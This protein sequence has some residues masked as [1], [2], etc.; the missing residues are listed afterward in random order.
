MSPIEPNA[1]DRE[2]TLMA[3]ETAQAPDAVEA[4]L[5]AHAEIHKSLAER[6]RARPPKLVM[7]C[8]RGS[9]D[10]AATYAKYL[11]EIHTGTPVASAAPAIASVYQVSLELDGALYLAVSQ[12][13]KSPDIVASARRARAAGA[14]V[15]ALVN[16]ASSPLAEAAEICIP[17][18]AG[19]EH[20]VAATKSFI[21]SLSAIAH[22]AAAW[23]E[24]RSLAAGLQRLPDDL[25]AACGMNWNQAVPDLVCADDLLVVGRG[26]GLALAQEAALKLKETASLHAEAFSAAELRH[27]P[28][29]IMRPGLPVLAFAQRDETFDSLRQLTADLTDKGARLMVAGAELDKTACLP[30]VEGLHPHLAPIAMA[31]SFYHLAN[32]VA[33]GRGIDPDRPRYLSKVT[34][35]R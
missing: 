30:V 5:S 22:I 20:S 10:H 27:G 18:M 13:G 2:A 24:D 32:E 35:T 7:T 16:D 11:I 8:A 28:L 31:Q 4:Q 23:S 34:E 26:V 33:L 15:V 6:L 1:G 21:A 3:M 19:A 9:S 29:A 25:R 12:S 17:L 14:L